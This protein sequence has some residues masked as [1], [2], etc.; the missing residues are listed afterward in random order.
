MAILPK[1]GRTA[2]AASIKSQPIHLGWGLGNGSW[3]TPPTEDTE[4]TELQ[5]EIGRRTALEV[6]FVVPDDAGEIVIDGAGRFS[7]TTDPTNRLYM[8]FKYDFADA[9]SAVIREIG[10]F[11]GTVTDPALPPGQLYFTPAQIVTPGYLLQLE[12]KAPIYRSSATRE[13]F[14]I[15]IT[16]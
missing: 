5:N 10:V 11:V 1:S 16:F 13:T 6:S 12:N 9:S 4:Q 2:I 3:T 8:Q 15:L 7:R 14:E